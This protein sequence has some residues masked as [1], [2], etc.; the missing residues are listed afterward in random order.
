MT[1]INPEELGFR[2]GPQLDAYGRLRVSNTYPIFDNTNEYGINSRDW[3]SRITGTGLV[4]HIPNEAAYQVSTG[5][6]ASGSGYVR[7]SRIHWRC[8]PGRA[9]YIFISFLYN[10]A[11]TNAVKRNGYYDDDNGVF[12]EQ[13]GSDIRFVKRT[14]ITGSVSDANFVTQSQWNTDRL[15]GTG[16]SGHTLD[17]TKYQTAFFDIFYSAGGRVRCGFVIDGHMCIAHEFKI[18]N[19]PL[20]NSW[21]TPHLPIRG[22]VLNTGVASGV[23]TARFR[24]SCLEIEAGTNEYTRGYLNTGSTGTIPLSVTTR[25]P[26]LSLRAKAL[27]NAITNHAWIV[28]YDFGIKT[29][30]NDIYYEIIVGGTLTGASW[31]SPAADSAGEYDIS[32]TTITGGFPVISGFVVAGQ[33]NLANLATQ[34]LIEKYPTSVDLNGGQTIYTIVATS[35]SGTANVSGVMNWREIY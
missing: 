12:F 10:G 15:D 17:L 26:I 13:N 28:P 4:T 11:V 19:T 27:L 21:R 16:P 9:S 23:A 2:E 33:G 22:E 14:N 3:V 34:Q 6:T 30:G 5:G 24:G 20:S 8:F 7:Q 35:F 18:G 31:V 25:R 32:A 29:S 1:Y